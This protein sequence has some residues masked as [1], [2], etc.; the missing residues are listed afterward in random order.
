MATK[1]VT[2][3]VTVTVEYPDQLALDDETI[4][5]AAMSSLSQ[6]YETDVGPMGKIVW[7]KC[8]SEVHEEDCEVSD[9]A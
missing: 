5:T 3:Q 9:F 2:M 6:S 1:Y 4:I 7:A 8:F